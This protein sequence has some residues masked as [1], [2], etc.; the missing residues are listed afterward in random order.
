MFA[1]IVVEAF[2]LRQVSTSEGSTSPTVHTA[3]VVADSRLDSAR[4]VAQ[5][6]LFL[7]WA[8]KFK[9]SVG[10]RGHRKGH[11]STPLKKNLDKSPSGVHRYCSPQ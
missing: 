5:W 7:T 8:L 2:V 6:V 9:T 11:T 10:P 4:T 1:D 3:V